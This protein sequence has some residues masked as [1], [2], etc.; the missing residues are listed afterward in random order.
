MA[1]HYRTDE[2]AAGCLHLIMSADTRAW[3]DCMAHRL[4]GET[5]ILLDN[6]VMHLLGVEALP[7]AVVALATD[8]AAHGIG[9]QAV[10]TGVP[11]WDD[12]Q[13]VAHLTCCAHVISWK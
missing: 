4:D 13:W 6:G 3:R 9:S 11:L 8:V 7:A 2:S 5:V 10:H 1:G 12:A